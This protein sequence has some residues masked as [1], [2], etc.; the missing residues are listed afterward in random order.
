SG[1]PWY[2]TCVVP[3]DRLVV[4]RSEAFA[5]APAAG[6][7]L[8]VTGGQAW[9]HAP[10]HVLFVPLSFLKRYTVRP[11]ASTRI[12]PRLPFA[13]RTVGALLAALLA[14]EGAAGGVTAA[15]GVLLPPPQPATMTAASGS[16][17]APARKLRGLT[18]VIRGPLIGGTSN[19]DRR[20][21]SCR[22]PQGDSV[23]YD[24]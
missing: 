3:S 22:R 23:H 8:T 16:T 7:P 19:R 17:A 14:V 13:T 21:T 18:R 5:P 9:A 1:W 11:C 15:F 2:V 12:R 6:L 20:N 4:P 10:L 24:S